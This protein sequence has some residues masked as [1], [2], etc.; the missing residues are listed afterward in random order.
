MAVGLPGHGA[1]LSA[2]IFSTVFRV[3]E[4]YAHCHMVIHVC[5]DRV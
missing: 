1:K 3:S 2:D 4:T 5:S